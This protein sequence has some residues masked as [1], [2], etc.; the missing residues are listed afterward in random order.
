MAGHVSNEIDLC[1]KVV[2]ASYM[3]AP[4]RGDV[5]ICR[6]ALMEIGADGV[7]G[8]VLRPGDPGYEQTKQAA[9]DAGRLMELPGNR[10]LL[11]GFVDLHVHAPQ[12]PQLGKALD[13]PLEVWL[14][15][16]TFPLEARYSDTGFARAV[17][18]DLV[19]SLL[20]HGTTTALYFA[21]VH[22]QATRILADTC[23]EKGQRG[24]IGKVVMDEP[25]QCPD[26]YRDPS[27]EMAL[28]G[29]R[30]F[31]DYVRSM[32]GNG[33][34]L[35]Q[36]VVTPRFVPSCTDEA[37]AGLGEIARTCGCH[38]QTH[39]SESDWEHGYVL[40]RTGMTDTAALSEFGLMG[41]HTVLAHSNFIT[42]ADME[43]IAA[44]GAGIAHCPLSNIYFSNAVFPLRR[45][46]EKSLRIG[47]GTDISG[48]P[49]ASMFDSCRQAIASSRLLE[50]GVDPSCQG[51]SRGVANSRIDFREAF[52]LATA[53]GADV[54][55]LPVG[56]FAKGCLFD[57]ILLDPEAEAA[58]IRIDDQIDTLDDQL[59]RIINGA[60]RANIVDVWVSGKRTGL[61][62]Q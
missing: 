36:P 34:N 24:L 18:G 51:G 3:H 12:W 58:P 33:T 45:A 49:S 27:T 37:L 15:E 44:A 26:Y 5:D 53:G 20:A 10:F 40:E 8:S 2:R 32:P 38:V 25:T 41:R 61:P 30:E 13:V 52:H 47:L 35:V 16:Y 22:Q 56:R 50:D 42:E 1:G 6:D 9:S 55:D 54:L 17:Y 48:G 43:M 62:P 60:T 4:V 7:I 11:P 31:I 19:A 23:L 46:L 29:T 57:A 28:Q 39:C 59:Q 14:Q 21:T